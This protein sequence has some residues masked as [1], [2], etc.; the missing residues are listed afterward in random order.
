MQRLHILRNERAQSIV[1]ISLIT[2]LLLIALYIP[3]DFGV[4]LFAA[5]LTQNA[6]REVARIA[7]A[8][9]PSSFN[10]TTLTNNELKP[11]LPKNVT[12]ISS[13]SSITKFTTSPANC[14]GVVVVTATVQY[15]FFWYKLMRFFGATVPNTVDIRRTTQMRYEYQPYNTTNTPCTA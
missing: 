3:F 4:S 1:E 9:A 8:Q 15:P 13:S 7:A 10:S 2:P 11:R 14:M 6:V 12:L 5:H